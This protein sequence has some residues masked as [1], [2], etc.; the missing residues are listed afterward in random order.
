MANVATA[1]GLVP[2]RHKSGA[3]YIGQCNT[4]HAR[5]DYATDLFIGDPVIVVATADANGIQDVNLATAGA[6]NKI[7][8]VIVGFQPNRDNLKLQYGAASTDRYIEVCDDPWVV[9]ELTLD[10]TAAIAT[11]NIGQNINL[12]SGTGNK[13]TGYSGWLGASTAFANNA[14]Y[15]LTIERVTNRPDNVI[16][17][18]S[19]SCHVEVSI[20]LHQKASYAIAGI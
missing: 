6:T 12:A 20:N 19:L 7:T 15:Q 17:G 5:S 4:Y 1:R 16:D 11:T 9:F 14:T 10:T 8:G 3:P 13:N 18:S 2:V